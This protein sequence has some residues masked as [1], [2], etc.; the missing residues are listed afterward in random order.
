MKIL[1]KVRKSAEVVLIAVILLGIN[2]TT[3]WSQA[4][5]PNKPINLILPMAAGGATDIAA[6]TLADVIEK[7]LGQKFVVVNKPGASGTV[8]GS[9]IAQAK[10]DGYTLGVFGTNQ[11]MPEVFKKYYESDYTA[12]D[13]RHVAQFSM[14]QQSMYCKSDK[15]FKTMKEFLEYARNKKDPV[16]VGIGGRGML[17]EVAIRFAENKAGLKNFSYVPLNGEAAVIPAVL[18][19]HVEVGMGNITPLI[20]HVKNGT[21]RL[22]V[23]LADFK[24]AD[25]PNLLNVYDLGYGMGARENF[26]GIGAPKKTPEAIVNKLEKAIEQATKDERFIAAMNKVDMAI[27]YKNA[28][29]YEA[30]VQEMKKALQDMDR[31]GFL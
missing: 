25:S 14:Y 2:A 31:R 16:L 13:I 24:M 22:L 26:V 11:A 7:Y 9:A 1:Q 5:Y 10:P 4:D 30:L 28:G 21:L 12:D 19:G 6:R 29:K 18:G 23:L 8:M 15:P 17:S 3:V 27:S 20:P